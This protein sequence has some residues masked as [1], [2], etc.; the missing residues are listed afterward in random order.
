MLKSYKYPI[1]QLIK[2]TF[3]T[4]RMSSTSS[5]RMSSTSSSASLVRGGIDFSKNVQLKAK[6]NSSKPQ[7]NNS[8]RNV[9]RGGYRRNGPRRGNR[10]RHGKKQPTVQRQRNGFNSYD[11]MNEMNP[12]PYHPVGSAEHTAYMEN[13]APIHKT[14]APEFDAT[15]DG[16]A[17]SIQTGFGDEIHETPQDMVD[18]LGWVFQEYDKDE[19][20]KKDKRLQE[21]YPRGYFTNDNYPKQKFPYAGVTTAEGKFLIPVRNQCADKHGLCMKV[22]LRNG[23]WGWGQDRVVKYEE[24]SEGIHDMKSKDYREKRV[25]NRIAHEKREERIKNKV[26]K[27]AHERGGIIYAPKL[28]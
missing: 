2:L 4:T 25:R 17:E 18:E 10:N 7:Y 19:M 24:T 27:G 26:L 13:K 3:K 23:V 20:T 15:R 9:R 14:T 22:I 28:D 21:E 6:Q 16:Y 1:A 8:E 11:M 12:N 5:S